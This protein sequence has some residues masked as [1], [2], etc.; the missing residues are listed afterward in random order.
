MM[1]SSMSQE[2]RE[3]M[4]YRFPEK[5]KRWPLLLIA[6]ALVQ[7]VGWWSL[8]SELAVGCSLLGGAALVA[9]AIG[10][11][12]GMAGHSLDWR[13]PYTLEER[14]KINERRRG[15]DLS[16]LRASRK[17]S[18]NDGRFGISILIY[19]ACA[20]F[21]TGFSAA[22]CPAMGTGEGWFERVDHVHDGASCGA[23]L[24]IACVSLLCLTPPLY[25]VRKELA[26]MRAADGVPAPPV[27][28]HAGQLAQLTA[29]GYGET[30]AVNALA[31]SRG[32]V[33]RA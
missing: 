13:R 32:D 33:A 4:R 12:E 23:A 28:Q 19:G 26:A 29:M 11:D 9:S 7:Q 30:V 8:Y 1:W 18:G 27:Q 22:N 16:E 10:F 24:V 17:K 6:G 15:N 5:D 2:E 14:R 21:A 3:G 20:L 25:Y 31:D